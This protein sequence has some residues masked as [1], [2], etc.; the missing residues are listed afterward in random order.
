VRGTISE[1][2]RVLKGP[3]LPIDRILGELRHTLRTQD[4]LVLEAPPGA[5]KTTRVPL[6]L[7]D[8]PWL[9]AQKIVMLEPRRLAARAAAEHMAALLGEP[10]GGTVGYRMRLDTRVGPR[11]RIE[12]LTEGVLTRLVQSDPSLA[13]IELVIFDEFH[14]RSLDADLGLA[15]SLHGRELFRD[16]H[17]LRVLLMSATL[18][19]A[20]LASVLGDAPIL[21]CAGRSH[22]VSVE[23]CPPPGPASVLER[24]LRRTVLRALHEQAGSVLVFLPG[25]AE[26]RRLHQTLSEALEPDSG[27]GVIPL[28]G[29]LS[30]EAQRQAIEPAPPGRRKIVLA[31][32]I[33]ETSL[34]IEGIGAV[35]DA[36]LS[37]LPVFDPA[38]GMTRLHTRRLSRSA[39]VQRMGRAGRLGPGRCYRLWSQAQQQRLP[40]FTPAE[41]LQADLAPL[42]LQLL[43]WGVDDPGELK[44]LDPPPPGAYAQALDLLDRL[45]ALRTTGADRR[46]LT[47]HGQAMARLPAHPRLAHLLLTGRRHGLGRLAGDLAA[48]L[49]ERDPLP[50][51]DADLAR[52]LALLWE[53][54]MLPRGV[55]GAIRR[56]RQQSRR[57]QA[58]CPA[59]TSRQAFDTAGRGH[60]M[61]PGEEAGP[62]ADPD[63]PRWVG[64]L[65][66]CAYPDRI[67]QRRQAG[68]GGYRLS[69]GRAAHLSVEDPLSRA[70]WLAVAQLGAHQGQ[71][72]ER[73][74]LAAGLD[75]RLFDGP[76][77]PQV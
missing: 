24:E 64:F 1:R 54:S 57:L 20:A 58:L 17:P 4:T 6:A 27:V 26:I 53:G 18:D 77:A 41:I 43:H 59:S 40:P 75:P 5:G 52:R 49:S 9:G 74:Y 22:P 55:Q 56:L 3:A 68:A 67:A 7:R 63:H 73:I 16:T 69:S 25:Q 12:V 32:A 65:L 42:A 72:S 11:T 29:D 34:T 21:R 36:G 38:S 62:V 2:A 70:P 50:R 45:G 71:S 8:E 19:G 48:L 10:V 61:D 13:G 66:A 31:T 30:L 14:E 33:A 51:G 39:S 35:V 44:W 23:Y 37:R 15:L 28:Y 46:S 76:L 47:P 60:A